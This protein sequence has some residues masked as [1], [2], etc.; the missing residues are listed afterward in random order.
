MQVMD[1]SFMGKLVIWSEL[2]SE[3]EYHDHCL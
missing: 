2:G 1:E 3:N